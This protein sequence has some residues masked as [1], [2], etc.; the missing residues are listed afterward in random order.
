MNQERNRRNLRQVR[1][2]VKYGAAMMTMMGATHYMLITFEIEH[3]YCHLM[4]CACAIILGVYLNRL[5]Q[6]CLLHQACVWYIGS[7]LVLMTVDQW[8]ALNSN[9][10]FTGLFSLVGI[11]LFISMLWKARK[12]C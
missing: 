7:A 5:F 9:H 6:L 4:W 12:G 10:T 11:T 2:I 8:T 3:L 1:A